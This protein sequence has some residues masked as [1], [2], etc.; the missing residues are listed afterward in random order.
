VTHRHRPDLPH[1]P[2][3]HE[4]LGIDLTA[5]M[6]RRAQARIGSLDALLVQRQPKTAVQE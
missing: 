1:L 4:Y 2:A 6:L 5:A 3:S